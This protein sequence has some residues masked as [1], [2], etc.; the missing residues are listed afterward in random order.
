MKKHIQILI[1]LPLVFLLVC[2]LGA[3]NHREGEAEGS[4]IVTLTQKNYEQETSAGVVL[5]DMWAPWCGPCRKM[6]PDIKAIAEENE[7]K[8]KVGKM[9]VEN[10]KRFAIK[11][12]VEMLPTVIV[13]KDGVE[14]ERAVG[15]LSKADLQALV[16]KYTVA[17]E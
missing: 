16:D 13:Y 15:R 2:G 5:V 4:P 7:S 8:I 11:L 17:G 10:Y 14:K 3:V 12:G 1:I 6:A 9:N